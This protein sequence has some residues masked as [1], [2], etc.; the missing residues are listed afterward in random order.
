MGRRRRGNRE[1]SREYTR[2]SACVWRMGRLTWDG[3]AEAVSRD[4]IIRRVRGQGNII[5]PVQLTTGRI[6]NLTRLIHTLLCVMTIRTCS[7]ER[8]LCNHFSGVLY[9]IQYKLM[10]LAYLVT[11]NTWYDMI[12]ILCYACSFVRTICLLVAWYSIS[13]FISTNHSFHFVSPVIYKEVYVFR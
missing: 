5:F 4:Q 9:C 6:G 10:V 12:L 1:E 8:R 3:T 2:D 7:A 11:I 13:K